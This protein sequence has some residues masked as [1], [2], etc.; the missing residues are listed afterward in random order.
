MI[1]AWEALL[2]TLRQSVFFVLLTCLIPA[3]TPAA[4]PLPDAS[5]QGAKLVGKY[6][7]QCHAAPLPNFHTADE[8]S[9]VTRRM[10]QRMN[11]EI[12]GM[13]APTEYEMNEILSY[14]QKK[15]P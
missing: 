7:G 4:R 10:Q 6:C 14:L 12:E 3:A 2:I 9:S 8:W 11:S 5:S 15:A 1:T 13:R